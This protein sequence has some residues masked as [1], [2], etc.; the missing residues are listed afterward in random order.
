[1]VLWVLKKKIDG[2]NYYFK[3]NEFNWL[4]WQ[5]R[6]GPWKGPR[7]RVDYENAGG[8]GEDARRHAGEARPAAAERRHNVRGGR[9]GEEREGLRSLFLFFIIIFRATPLSEGNSFHICHSLLSICLYL[10]LKLHADFD[11]EL[12]APFKHREI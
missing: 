4:N 7:N 10:F 11:D 6:R 2:A 3:K 9:G 5:A 12:D 8:S 1:V